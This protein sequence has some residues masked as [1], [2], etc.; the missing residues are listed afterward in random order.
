MDKPCY[1]DGLE[2]VCDGCA[3]NSDWKTC[4]AGKLHSKEKAKFAR[5]RKI[6]E[7]ITN[8]LYDLLLS[9]NYPGNKQSAAIITRK[10]VKA[11]LTKIIKR[12][13]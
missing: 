11:Q 1:A 5:A 13:L 4:V 3:N 12:S 10:K 8:H 2:D 6:R 7:E 9:F